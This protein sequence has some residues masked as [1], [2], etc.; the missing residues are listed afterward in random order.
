MAIES[1]VHR[2]NQERDYTEALFDRIAELVIANY[3]TINPNIPLEHIQQVLRNG[4]VEP[5]GNVVDEN[6]PVVI[7]EKDKVAND[8]D[9]KTFD[10]VVNHF[11]QNQEEGKVDVNTIGITIT[12]ES[13]ILLTSP[14]LPDLPIGVGEVEHLFINDNV[15][16]FIG[17]ATKKNL[18]HL[19]KAFEYLETKITEFKPQYEGGPEDV[20]KKR[21]SKLFKDFVVIKKYIKKGE[22][23]QQGPELSFV[24]KTAV[25]LNYL[26]K[27]C[28]DKIYD[29]KCI[30]TEEQYS[31]LLDQYHNLEMDYHSSISSSQAQIEVGQDTI[32]SKNTV[33][34]EMTTVV[35][36]QVLQ[37]FNVTTYWKA[38]FSDAIKVF[39][40]LLDLVYSKIQR[41]IV[42][43]ESWTF[44]PASQ[45]LDPNSE[46]YGKGWRIK[47]NKSNLNNPFPADNLL[48]DAEEVSL[49]RSK[50][51]NGVYA[52]GLIDSNVIF[53]NG[54][55]NADSLQNESNS[56]GPFI[57]NQPG[58]I[59][60][61]PS[62]FYY[63]N[64]RGN[65]YQVDT[66]N[67]II[68]TMATQPYLSS[69]WASS[70]YFNDMGAAEIYNETQNQIQ[71]YSGYPMATITNAPKTVTYAC[72]MFVGSD[73]S[74]FFD[75]ANSSMWDSNFSSDFLVC[76]TGG[77]DPVDITTVDDAQP[78]Y[79][80]PGYKHNW[81]W[82][83]GLG[84]STARK[85]IP[86]END[87]I[88]GQLHR[89][90]STNEGIDFMEISAYTQIGNASL[91][92]TNTYGEFNMAGSGT[93]PFTTYMNHWSS[94]VIPTEFT[95]KCS[96]NF[97]GE[98]FEA[99]SALHLTHNMETAEVTDK[100]NLNLD[101]KYFKEGELYCISLYVKTDSTSLL[102]VQPYLEVYIKEE[103]E[104]LMTYKLQGE[105]IVG[106]PASFRN[107]DNW[108]RVIFNNVQP[109]QVDADNEITYTINF[110][111]TVNDSNSNEASVSP[112]LF[113]NTFNPNISVAGLQVEAGD[114][115]TAW[116]KPS[117]TLQADTIQETPSIDELTSM[118]QDTTPAL[119][120]SLMPAIA[121]DE[122]VQHSSGFLAQEIPADNNNG[123]TVLFKE[124]FEPTNYNDNFFNE[125][126]IIKLITNGSLE[127]VMIVENNVYGNNNIFQV[128]R[129]LYDSSIVLHSTSD[130]YQLFD[131]QEYI[132]TN[133]YHESLSTINA[134]DIGWEDDSVSAL[135]LEIG[136]SSGNQSGNLIVSTNFFGSPNVIEF[137]ES[138]RILKINNELFYIRFHQPG[139]DG[140]I[141]GLTRGL[142]GTLQQNHDAGSLIYV[143]K[144]LYDF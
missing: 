44:T 100:N 33:V 138:S 80:N 69:E 90:A 54:E 67:A 60:C 133:D 46:V 112:G 72:I 6:I 134:G 142:G 40:Q 34:D 25:T 58:C 55:F 109:P 59:R 68:S 42:R 18:L 88:I 131:L 15:S 65:R 97:N 83:N 21:I 30:F 9:L 99:Y 31:T 116:R 135:L 77:G 73:K 13:E 123:F 71:V 45:R 141:T 140:G 16:Q 105:H 103:I 3:N 139:N 93:I 14:G 39:V 107:T 48:Q 101:T 114:I 56:P 1:Y 17:V 50:S 38:Q 104:G 12:G 115:V 87:A 106:L 27:Q 126:N 26:I 10:T 102:K 108:K 91:D 57:Q 22:T 144:E 121:E 53:Y 124:T 28:I 62:V 19:D 47:Q 52:G 94:M 132:G 5:R 113:S 74:R 136:A 89:L 66:K 79:T 41:N 122:F 70:L 118:Y 95:F 128:V 117:E 76:Y 98:T 63:I 78:V 92:P 35:F 137:Q 129:G 4:I 82:D 49:S 96:P 130:S 84:F 127:Y 32:E 51:R 36:P 120:T 37:S 125:G 119:N 2:I 85:F 24:D 110:K 75:G 143:S 43:Y 8:S 20:L 86:N 64:P 61:E 7:F 29:V 111:F 11:S 81:Y 23:F